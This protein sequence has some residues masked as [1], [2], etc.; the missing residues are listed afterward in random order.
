MRP[1]LAAR[2]FP[3]PPSDLH[4]LLK[5]LPSIW[6]RAFHSICPTRK[7]TAESREGNFEFLQGITKT[8]FKEKILT[9][10]LVYPIISPRATIKRSGRSGHPYE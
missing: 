10:R 8:K 2:N 7:K 6:G 5:A 1:P 3:T 4:G 9:W